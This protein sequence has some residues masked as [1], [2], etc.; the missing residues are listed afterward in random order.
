MA[1][2]DNESSGFTSRK[3]SVFAIVFRAYRSPF[4]ALPPSDFNGSESEVSPQISRGTQPSP[5]PSFPR[6]RESSIPPPFLDS[7]PARE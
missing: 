5:C 6:K 3:Q 2:D 4:R 1:G 7:K